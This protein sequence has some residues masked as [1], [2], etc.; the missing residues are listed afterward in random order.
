MSSKRIYRLAYHA[1]QSKNLRFRIHQLR[2]GDAFAELA[3]VLYSRGY[4]YGGLFLNLPPDEPQQASPVDVSFLTS[5]DLL[6]LNTRPPLDDIE[7]D[8]KKRVPLGHTSLEADVFK[9]LKLYFRTCAR[10]HIKLSENV[11]EQLPADFRNRA[12]I[13]FRQC[14]DGSYL[15]YRGYGDRFWQK[16]VDERLTAFY[17]IQI[18]SLWKG[19]PGLLAAFGMAGTETLAWNYLLR[20]R[21]QKWVGAYQFIMAEV[22]PS[23]LPKQP[24]DLTFADGWKVR[25]IIRIPLQ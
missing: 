21:F 22:V 11:A 12:N 19:G 7:E 24:T 9:A 2:D 25:P 17:L 16:P 8:D 23:K 18:P 5:S 6:V 15:K 3:A 20:T 10:S 13:M 4:R 1:S 14:Y